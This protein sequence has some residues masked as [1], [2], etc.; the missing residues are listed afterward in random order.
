MSSGK[1]HVSMDGVRESS[2][3]DT[4][5]EVNNVVDHLSNAVPPQAPFKTNIKEQPVT[6]ERK[7]YAPQKGDRLINAGTARATIAASQES[8]NGTTKG[9]YARDHQHQ[10]VFDRF[11]LKP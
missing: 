1:I 8:P 4:D 9:N 6:Q 5:V 11:V 3:N 2:S 10:T 7:P